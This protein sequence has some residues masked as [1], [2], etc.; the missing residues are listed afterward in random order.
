MK[1][2]AFVLIALKRIVKKTL[3]QSNDCEANSKV[4]ANPIAAQRY[5][6]PSEVKT[7]FPPTGYAYVVHQAP[8]NYVFHISPQGV[9]H[10]NISNYLRLEKRKGG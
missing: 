7:P 1:L 3:H 4:F 8:I 10:T 2:F 5:S 6:E 9:T